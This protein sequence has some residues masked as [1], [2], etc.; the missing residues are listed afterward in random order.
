[1]CHVLAN[2]V[3]DSK[4]FNEFMCEEDYEVDE[5][6]QEII[7]QHNLS[8]DDFAVGKQTDEVNS[9]PKK[10]QNEKRIT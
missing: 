7:H 9:L 2:W 5:S 1:M 8:I 10:N 4:E 3:T 6:G